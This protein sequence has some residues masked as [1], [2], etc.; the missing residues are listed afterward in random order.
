MGSRT[1]VDDEFRSGILP[2]NN[3]EAD[4]TEG[5]IIQPA[6]GFDK[7]IDPDVSIHLDAKY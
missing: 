1:A 6:D 4:L 7:V 3:T 2:I 5:A